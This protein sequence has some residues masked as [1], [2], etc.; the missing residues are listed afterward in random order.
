LS[1]QDLARIR[2]TV[3]LARRAPARIRFEEDGSRVTLTDS[4][5]FETTLQ[6]GGRKSRETVLDGGDVDTKARWDDETLV[7]ERRVDGG[8]RVTERYTL[9]LGGVRLLSFIAVD[10]LQQPLEFTRQFER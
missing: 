2:Q 3:A 1:E 7:I 9:G 6:I 8:G 10:G 4:Q 5:G